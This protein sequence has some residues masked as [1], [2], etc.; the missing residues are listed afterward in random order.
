MEYTQANLG[1]TFIL[2]FDAEEDILE[3]LKNLIR[4]ERMQAGTVQ[5]IGALTNTDVVIGPNEKVYP[6]EP[7]LRNFDDAKE[8]IAYGIFAWE[9]NEPK[10]HLHSGFGSKSEMLVGCIRNKTEVYLT[11]EGVIQEFIDTKVARKL[12]TRYNAS[13]LSFE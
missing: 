2:R 10:L 12:D 4:K 11:I 9:G 13:L 6:P 3:E 7:V 1:R 8:I 5:L